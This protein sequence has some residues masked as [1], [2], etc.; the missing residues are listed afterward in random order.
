LFL[1]SPRLHPLL[2][3]ILGSSLYRLPRHITEAYCLTVFNIGEACQVHPLGYKMDW[4]R[5]IKRTAIYILV[6]FLGSLWTIICF[7]VINARVCCIG[8]MANCEEG[9][10]GGCHDVPLIRAGC[11]EF[12]EESM[13][14]W[15]WL[16]SLIPSEGEYSD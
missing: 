6:I 8:W 2:L 12:W 13:V 15:N 7:V 4:L 14:G 1:Q 9:R 16:C 10:T 5:C 3:S 11:E